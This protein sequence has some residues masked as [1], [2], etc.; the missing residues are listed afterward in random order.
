MTAL[1]ERYADWYIQE[2]KKNHI[3]NIQEADRQRLL[4][5]QKLAALKLATQS[6]YVAI[7][8]KLA[9][10]LVDIKMLRPAETI[11]KTLMMATPYKDFNPREFKDK[12]LPNLD[13][14]K[15]RLDDIFN[16][17]NAQYHLILT[18]A[19]L[20]KNVDALNTSQVQFLKEFKVK[21]ITEQNFPLIIQIIQKLTH[22]INRISIKRDELFTLFNRPLTPD[23]IIE[24]FK[25]L[26]NG[27]LAGIDRSNARISLD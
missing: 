14:L 11:T 1:K 8:P 20:L 25:N 17:A 12:T 26:V 18:D 3:T 7:E 15:T 16:F 4:N 9:P 5:S 19:N 22:G 27:K 13:D 23:E 21:Q 2:Y 10:W 24:E 6:N